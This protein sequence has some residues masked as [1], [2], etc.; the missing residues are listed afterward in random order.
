MWAP[1]GVRAPG[2]T[3][4]GVWGLDME[5]AG[6]EVA[7]A[8]GEERAGLGVWGYRLLSVWCV[9]ARERGVQAQVRECADP[10]KGAWEEV[11]QA[12]G[13]LL[14]LDQALH[15]THLLLPDLLPPVPRQ[16]TFGQGLESFKRS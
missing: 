16:D 11:V 8:W 1:E 10:R 14:V 15:P 5:D 6:N 9:A 3:A 4:Q 13:A 12:G 7:Q 2:S